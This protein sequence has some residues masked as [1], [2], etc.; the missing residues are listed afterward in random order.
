MGAAA[1]TNEGL[2][3]TFIDSLVMSASGRLYAGTD[4]DGVFGYE[5]QPIQSR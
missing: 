2:T 1:L 3:S 4:G 5:E